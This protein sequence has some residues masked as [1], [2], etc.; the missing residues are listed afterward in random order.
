MAAQVDIMNDACLQLGV[1]TITAP[2]DTSNQARAM[3]AVWAVER[4]NELRAHWWKFAIARGSL[5][6][7]ASVP[8]SGPFK[9]QFQLPAGWL[10]AMEIGDAYPSVDL[11]DY[12]SGDSDD[13]YSI[14]GGMILT[15]YP[16]PL[17][18]RYIQQIVNPGLF[19]ADFA[20]MLACRLAKTC[21]YRL[22]N[23]LELAKVAMQN[24]KDALGDAIRA[25]ALE[26]V[27]VYPADDTWIATRLGDGGSRAFVNF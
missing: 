16:A 11:S 5:P 7:L 22:T 3:N 15:N 24:Y 10:R 21:C 20:K 12:R 8:V 4:D 26:S 27:P 18:V 9:T 13:A 6:A 17:T 1:A 19:D 2:S 23:S 14:E 25:N